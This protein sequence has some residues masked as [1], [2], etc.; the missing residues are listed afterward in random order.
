MTS[1]WETCEQNE[2]MATEFCRETGAIYV[3]HCTS[4]EADVWRAA[5]GVRFKSSADARKDFVFFMSTF[6][7]NRY[8]LFS[9]QAIVA[10]KDAHRL[11]MSGL[12]KARE[13]DLAALQKKKDAVDEKLEALVSAIR[14]RSI[15]RLLF[16]LFGLNHLL[17]GE[18]T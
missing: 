2:K 14:A 5:H 6:P 17:A 7:H 12:N 1:F 11:E 8:A 13:K 3:L 18:T 4:S 16:S 10:L 9:P 15:L